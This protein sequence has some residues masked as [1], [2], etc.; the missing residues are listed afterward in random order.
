M[1]METGNLPEEIS[2]EAFWARFGGREESS[3][4]ECKETLTRN[5]RLQEPVVA[6]GNTRGGTILIGVRNSPRTIVGVEWGERAE[7]RIQELSRAIQPPHEISSSCLSVD[8]RLVGV[9]TVRPVER[10][11]LQTSDGRLLVR[12]GPTNRALVGQELHRFILERGAEPVEDRPVRD[13]GLEDLDLH[14]VDRYIAVRLSEPSEDRDSDLRNLGFLTPRGEVRL[15][16]LLLFGRSPQSAGRRFGI[17]LLR[18][19][20]SVDSPGELRDRRQLDGRAPELVEN[21]YTRISEEM[22]RDSVIRGLLRE[23]V[24]E[25]P[26]V[27]IREALLNA[28]GH[29]DYSLSGSSIQVRLFAD[30][31]EIESPGGLAG[32]VTVDNLRDAQYSRN[33]RLMDAFHDLDLVEEAGTGIDRMYSSMEDALLDAPEFQERDN[34]FV[35]R[36]RGR[37]IFSAEDRLW[38]GGF[39]GLGLTADEKVALVFARRHKQVTNHDLRQLR[40]LDSSGS[41]SV[42]QDLVARGLLDAVGERRGTRYVL[43][44]LALETVPP[45]PPDRAVGAVVALVAQQGSVVNADVR[46]L[47]EVDAD[48]ARALLGQAVAQG[49]L[50][51]VGERRGRRYILRGPSASSHELPLHLD[52]Q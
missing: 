37:S 40:P 36:L 17:D 25:Y 27:V 20:G 3:S 38:I 47:L 48:E 11:W 15:A 32:W 34:A 28:V 6:F 1:E 19:E 7:E 45:P 50:E 12:A 44:A 31:I 10:G 46:Q 16:A 9:L 18:F 5:D 13:V 24:P 4:V 21:A 8:G 33:V 52:G 2:E 42:L 23:E 35:V 39:R 14:A 26:P 22:R 29:R 30:G 43:S 51:P 41:R 49:L